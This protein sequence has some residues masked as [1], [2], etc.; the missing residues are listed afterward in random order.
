MPISSTA[1]KWGVSIYIYIYKYIYTYIYNS[2]FRSHY[3]SQWHAYNVKRRCSDLAPIKYETF[4]IQYKEIN[5]PNKVIKCTLTG[6]VFTSEDAYKRYTQTRS[7]KKYQQYK[8]KDKDKDEQNIKQFN[9]NDNEP[10]PVGSSLFDTHEPFPTI[11]ELQQYM[12]YNYG[13]FIP[14]VNFLIDIEGQL[15]YLGYKIGVGHICILCHKQFPSTASVQSHMRDKGHCFISL[16]D[17]DGNDDIELAK[18]YYFPHTI[19]YDIDDEDEDGDDYEYNDN[20]DEDDEEQEYDNDTNEDE[21]GDID[22]MAIREKQRRRTLEQMH[23]KCE[24]DENGSLLT[25]P[26]IPKRSQVG[27]NDDNELILDDGSMIGNKKKWNKYKQDIL[28]QKYNNNTKKLELENK[29]NLLLQ[30]RTSDN[31][32]YQKDTKDIYKQNSLGNRK[33][34]FRQIRIGRQRNQLNRLRFRSQN[35]L[36]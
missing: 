1:F 22:D 33:W 5:K 26:S 2:I 36:P 10:I 4:E 30:Y 27:I 12:L 32:L 13:F 28:K 34:L 3:E 11:Y 14:F 17:I 20:E 8:N 15:L 16:Q 21:Y 29:K 7:Y 9:I 25:L 35:T 18:M 23:L 6:K 19:D 24:P 31:K